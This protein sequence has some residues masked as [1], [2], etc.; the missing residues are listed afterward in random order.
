MKLERKVGCEHLPAYHALRGA[1]N[2]L[3]EQ[4]ELECVRVMT[5]GPN[6]EAE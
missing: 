4:S 2:T 6:R 5:T 3:C 1:L